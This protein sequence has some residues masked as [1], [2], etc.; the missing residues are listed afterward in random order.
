LREPIGG[1]QLWWNVERS[2]VRHQRLRIR[3]GRW[4]P[5]RKH[6]WVEWAM[7]KRHP[8]ESTPFTSNLATF[9]R[10]TKVDVLPI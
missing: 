3:R 1:H 9:P 10:S 2:H 4:N 5:I 8:P 7:R 6:G